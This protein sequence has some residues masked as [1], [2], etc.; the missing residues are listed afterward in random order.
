MAIQT[1]YTGD[2]NYVVN[3]DPNT[4]SIGTGGI[5]ATGLTKAPMAVKIL[6]PTSAGNIA[7]ET[8]TGGAVE[9]I[10]RSI[11][12][13]STIVMYQ[14]ETTGGTTS[15]QVSVLLEASGAGA[16]GSASTAGTNSS[17]TT[18]AAA[19]QTRLQALNS[20]GNIGVAGNIW[21]A[22]ITVTSGGFKL[23]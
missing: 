9:T 11:G 7:L 4:T 5:I 16:Q 19:L 8:V 10:L 18:V 14:V 1:R 2:S 15:N 22:G 12:I 20:A 3:M 13:D 6:A 23:A 21:A 17:P